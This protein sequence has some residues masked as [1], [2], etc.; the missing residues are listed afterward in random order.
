MSVL[1][2]LKKGAD[3]AA[4]RADAQ[5][6]GIALTPLPG[7]PR[8]FASP[9]FSPATFPL[10]GHPA[11]AAIDEGDTP[12]R[13]EEAQPISID[14]QMAG[15]SW[16]IARHIRRDAPWLLAPRIRAPIETFFRCARTGAGV[17]AYV[18]D[19]GLRY[20]HA[21]FGGRASFVGGSY[22]TGGVD[23]NGHGTS[24]AAVLAGDVVGLAR[25]ASLRIV[26]GLDSANAGTLTAVAT[27]IGLARA[28]FEARAALGRPAVLNLSLTANGPTIDAAV[29]ECIDAGL[30]VVAA[31]GNALTGTIGFPAA[32]ADVICVGGL[33]ANDTPYY[34]GNFGTSSGARVDILAGAERVWT[35]S[36][37]A[38]DAFRLGSG[39]SYATPLVAGALACMLQGRP[40]PASRTHVQAVRAALLSNATTGRFQP[41][42]QFPTGPL[43]DRILW[44]DP[45]AEDVPI[46]G[47]G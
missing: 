9:Q 36:F 27:A 14:R 1:L 4:F 33:K 28:D 23:D 46:P 47:L 44:L 26:K 5:A 45:D 20:D 31:A 16:A 34:A 42:P 41:Q 2:C 32:S 10:A 7:L 22:G 40:R 38:P 6:A 3:S 18:V 29:S 25:A 39:T 24:V 43:P 17:D 8:H 12:A 30:I 15:G 13:G 19:S 37:T 11:I 35:A 21:V